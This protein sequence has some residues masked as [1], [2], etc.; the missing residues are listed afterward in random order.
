MQQNSFFNA[1]AIFDITP[2]K[3]GENAFDKTIFDIKNW[4][5]KKRI[6]GRDRPFWPSTSNVRQYMRSFIY[7]SLFHMFHCTEH[8]KAYINARSM[9]I[10]NKI[11]NATLHTSPDKALA[12][13]LHTRPGHDYF[14]LKKNF[15]DWFVSTMV[16]ANVY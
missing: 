10:C 13:I 1:R 8:S 11:F 12:G 15:A 14:P 5:L 3:E 2:K 9:V 7:V 6:L 4:F 16:F